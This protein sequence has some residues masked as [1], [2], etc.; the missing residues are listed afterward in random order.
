M[1][2]YQGFTY[3]IDADANAIITVGSGSLDTV[4][5]VWEG[6]YSSIP[7]ITKTNETKELLELRLS[8]TL[9]PQDSFRAI[10]CNV[11]ATATDNYWSPLT[12]TRDDQDKIIWRIDEEVFARNEPDICAQD[13]TIV[14]GDTGDV[15]NGVVQVCLSEPAYGEPL[16]V[17][18]KTRDAT[19]I[20]GIG[21]RNIAY[22]GYGNPFIS[23]T[24]SDE[25]KLRVVY[26]GGFPKYYNSRN[27]AN[28]LQFLKNCVSYCHQLPSRPKRILALGDAGSS[29]PVD[30]TGSSGFKTTMLKVAADLGY[31]IDIMTINQ[32]Q[33]GSPTAA[34]FSNYAMM[35]YWSTAVSSTQVNATCAES[36][37]QAALAGLGLVIITDHNVFQYSANAI[38]AKFNS[39]FYGDVNRSP[40]SIETLKATYGDHV[41]WSNMSGS[42]FAG[43]SEGN[44]RNT[45]VGD[46]LEGNGEITFD[47][48]EQCKDIPIQVFGNEEITGSKFFHVDLYDKSHGEYSCQTAT[49]VISD[50]DI[51]ACGA[52]SSAGGDGVSYT[53]LTTGSVPTVVA[54]LWNAYSKHD[55]FDWYK[56]GQ[57]IGSSQMELDSALGHANPNPS[58]DRVAYDAATGG[59]DG[60]AV[61]SL[62]Q[63]KFNRAGCGAVFY[64]FYPLLTD[65]PFFADVRAEGPNG[66]GWDFGS[67]CSPAIDISNANNLA[68][69][70]KLFQRIGHI[71]ILDCGESQSTTQFRIVFR[72][73]DTDKFGTSN[74]TTFAKYD[75]GQTIGFQSLPCRLVFSRNRVVVHTT[76]WIAAGSEITVTI[77]KLPDDFRFLELMVEY[78]IT[79]IP[80][81]VI[82]TNV[83]GSGQ[84]KP[85][86]VQWEA[87]I[88]KV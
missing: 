62:R 77:D 82:E 80:N 86:R 67:M 52:S 44:V 12:F 48:G 53:K 36:I 79:G 39:Q 16:T 49:V 71:E 4:D 13:T 66:T 85:A 76:N 37:Y 63:N 81:Y 5:V 61:L 21:V 20:G 2:V 30:S 22:D 41:L 45:P 75:H 70:N 64:A 32:F 59:N 60:Q 87:T 3:E 58:Y 19:A 54:L 43:G 51:L 74:Q 47:I 17:K 14:E 8:K 38:A 27:D 33:G 10:E 7:Y 78:D 26:D 57:W 11:K 73:L 31:E 55:R 65:D 68:I 28:S 84:C 23:V 34:H 6:D 69:D 46:F 83:E 88:T 56:N 25:K 24:H 9:V 50:D 29:Y 1:S 72:N 18:W 42:L 40:V 15:T 35:F